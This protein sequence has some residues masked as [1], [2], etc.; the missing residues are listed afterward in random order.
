MSAHF[1]E[2]R[3]IIDLFRQL[4][5]ESTT[6]LRQEVALAKT[7][8]SEKAGTVGRNVAVAAVG[9][10]IAHLSLIFLL[11]AASAGIRVAIEQTNWSAHAIWIAP[12][13][14]GSI[15]GALGIAM[16][17]YAKKTLTNLSVK[18]E[19]TIRSLKEDKEWV[20]QKVA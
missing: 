16:M 1:T 2:S 18:P 6:L 7:E 14:V 15:V 19:K 20:Q 11:L 9:G 10:A 5:D 3:S 17:L 4:R 13:I 12:L 8:M